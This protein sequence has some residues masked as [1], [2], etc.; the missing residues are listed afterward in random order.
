MRVREAGDLPGPL[1][2]DAG[3]QAARA[4]VTDQDG[5]AAARVEQSEDLRRSGYSS[6]NPIGVPSST[7]RLLSLIHI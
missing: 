2:G 5:R 7:V 3:D 1:I 4:A 6:V